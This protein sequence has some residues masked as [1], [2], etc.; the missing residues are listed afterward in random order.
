MS[1]AYGRAL[2]PLQYTVLILRISNNALSRQLLLMH[3]VQFLRT[4]IGCQL[5]YHVSVLYNY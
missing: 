4:A 5:S 3:I 1:I 2:H